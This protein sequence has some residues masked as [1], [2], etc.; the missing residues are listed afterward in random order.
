MVDLKPL[1]SYLLTHMI[2]YIPN[3]TVTRYILSKEAGYLSISALDKGEVLKPKVLPFDKLIQIIVRLNIS[4]DQ[5]TEK[6][7]GKGEYMQGTCQC[8][9]LF[10]G[11]RCQYKG[12]IL[13]INHIL[14]FILL[15]HV[16]NLLHLYV[17]C[18][19]VQLHIYVI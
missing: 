17:Y 7:S 18:R 16:F 11:D 6:C 19:D 4:G 13:I 15:L 1:K 10:S 2:D 9:R 12:V 5:F 8:E 14:L 3:S